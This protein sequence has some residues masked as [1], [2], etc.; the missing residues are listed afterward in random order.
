MSLG[1]KETLPLFEFWESMQLLFRPAK[2]GAGRCPVNARV[3]ATSASAAGGTE[4]IPRL[5]GRLAVSDGFETPSSGSDPT[6]LLTYSKITSRPL[7]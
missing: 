6:G 1:V 7:Q 3:G 2:N 5:T 4:V